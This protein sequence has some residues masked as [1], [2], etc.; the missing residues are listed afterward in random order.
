ME[1]MEFYFA[2]QRVMII[3]ITAFALYVLFMLYAWWKS[4]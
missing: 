4:R 3:G 2:F 1:A